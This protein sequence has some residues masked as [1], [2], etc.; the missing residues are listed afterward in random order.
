[1][2]S[3]VPSR[4]LSLRP[5]LAVDGVLLLTALLIAWRTPGELAGG[6]LLGVIVCIGLGA[7]LTV[8]PFVLNDARE[9]EASLA[10]RQRELID[11]VNASSATATRWGTQW[12]AAATGLTDAAGLASRS[13]VAAERLPMVVQEKIDAFARLLES[14]EQAAHAR[15]GRVAAQVDA[16]ANALAARADK[17]S[18]VV[19]ELERTLADFGRLEA[20]V[21]E[22]RTA[23][24]S[25]LAEFPAAAARAHSARVE[26]EERLAA[27]P[28]Q[29]EA[30]VESRVARLVTEA[31]SRLSGATDALVAR[32]GGLDTALDA[33]MTRLEH[34][35]RQEFAVPPTVETVALTPPPP[36]PTPQPEPVVIIEAPVPLVPA[37]PPAPL[38]P[39]APPKAALIMDPFYIPGDGYSALAEAM[40]AGRPA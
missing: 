27:A 20:S 28:A 19:A 17:A 35:N 31:E 12:T 2:S 39:P 3:S 34:A 13:I 6:P 8:L 22:H 37:A 10:E 5:F 1:M 40:D 29:I 32:L 4:P 16:Q 14:A 9:R 25:T 11:L 38:E 33:L 18:A 36:A 26:L 7:V 30:R 24:A 23:L 15:E 21:R